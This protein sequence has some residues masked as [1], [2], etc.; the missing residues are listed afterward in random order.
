VGNDGETHIKFAT[1]SENGSPNLTVGHSIVYLFASLPSNVLESLQRFCDVLLRPVVKVEARVKGISLCVSNDI[2]LRPLKSDW[3]NFS[4][5]S[6]RPSDDLSR[7][8][9]GG[10]VSAKTKASKIEQNRYADP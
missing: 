8:M 9:R 10:S 4:C 5:E 3:S 7:S 6:K 2:A 1:E